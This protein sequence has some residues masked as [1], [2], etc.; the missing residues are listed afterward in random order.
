MAKVIAIG[1]PVNDSERR[2]IQFLRDR[3][4]DTYTIIHNFEIP[5]GSEKYEI[6]LAIIAPH[7][8]F[9]VDVKGI[10]GLIDI[11][12]SKWYPEG[13]APIHSPLAK[14][15]QHA[16]VIKTL[17]CDAHPAKTDLRKVQVHAAIL[18]TAPNAQV[19]DSTLR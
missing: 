12:G 6:D 1:Q 3:L 15:R 11:Y 13:R 16:K 7:S 5:Q 4:S 17:I 18:M 2:A 8:V 14:L 10:P 9:I 19:D